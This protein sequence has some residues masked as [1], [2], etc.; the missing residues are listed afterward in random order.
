MIDEIGKEN[1]RKIIPHYIRSGSG[2]AVICFH[3]S[4]SSS[5]QWQPLM[6]YLCCDHSAVALDLYGYGK[7]PPWSGDR[8]LSL[9][10]EAALI[11]PILAET[12]SPVTLVGHSY[13]GAV[14]ATAALEYPDQ[15]NGL[16]LYEPVLFNLLFEDKEAYESV[17]EALSVERMVNGLLMAGQREEA[18]RYFIDYWS[19]NGAFD[20]FP[21]WQKAA[22]GKRIDKVISDFDAAFRNRC[23]LSDYGTM[24][25]PTLLLY[26]MNSPISTRRIAHLLASSIPNVEIRGIMGFGHMGPVI[27]PG[28]VNRII[29]NFLQGI[30]RS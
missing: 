22:I 28:D 9:K 17:T 30:M 2:P 15:I 24:Q 14:A 19:G 11:K 8:R 16:I 29:G 20:L 1:T 25:I 23:F 21:D 13:G 5:K 10:D 12:G 3:C 4:T 7:T 27:N 18:A 26:G 6:D